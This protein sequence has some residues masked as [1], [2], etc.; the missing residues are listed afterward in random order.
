MLHDT[1][2]IIITYI[3][4]IQFECYLPKSLSVKA[5]D[6]FLLVK[7]VEDLRETGFKKGVDEF[8]S[9][10]PCTECLRLFGTME[11]LFVSCSFLSSIRFN[12]NSFFL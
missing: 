4:S 10:I 7:E 12:P 1:A 6:V 2:I 3:H 9:I 8:S 5:L 11:E